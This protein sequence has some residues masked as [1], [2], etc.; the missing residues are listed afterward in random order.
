MQAL[1]KKYFPDFSDFADIFI[2]TSLVYYR[3]RPEMISDDGQT[4]KIPDTCERILKLE[5]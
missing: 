5:R 3:K 1:Q 4:Q 2:Y